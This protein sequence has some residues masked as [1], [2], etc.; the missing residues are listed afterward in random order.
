M[1]LTEPQL[2]HDL[3]KAPSRS[4]IALIGRRVT[5]L[6]RD[7]TAHGAQASTLAPGAGRVSFTSDQ[8]AETATDP[9]AR[10][11]EAPDAPSRMPDIA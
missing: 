10:V 1:T 9:A 7:G 2:T 11:A 8:H 5:D 4:A 6:R 3:S